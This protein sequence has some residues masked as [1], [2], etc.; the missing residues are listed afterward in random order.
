M[1][2][3]TPASR[4]PLFMPL[5]FVGRNAA[6]IARR[7]WLPS[8]AGALSIYGFFA[9]YMLELQSYLSNPQDSVG[10][11]VLGIAALALLVLV[12]LHSLVVGRIA[13]LALGMP[14]TKGDFLGVTRAEWRLYTANL[15]FCIVLLFFILA[16]FGFW[17][18]TARLGW[19]PGP[20]A[21]VLQGLF[22]LWLT[23][24]LWFL[25]PPVCMAHSKGE[26][27]V[28]AWRKSSGRRIGRIVLQFAAIL[29]TAYLVQAAVGMLL[30]AVGLIAPLPNSAPLASYVSSYRENLLPMVVMIN[31]AYIVFAV[32]T[33]AAAAQVYAEERAD[34]P[35]A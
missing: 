18:V 20:A 23:A 6:L 5:Q 31:I 22:L 11:R 12:F 15:Q 26:V 33:A 1:T 30:H 34:I 3:L 24:R 19:S 7:I 21:Y 9:A 8:L 16:F 28:A 4:A 29:L 2:A 35:P 13:Q 25:L 17:D 27:L 32:L 10:S 14:A